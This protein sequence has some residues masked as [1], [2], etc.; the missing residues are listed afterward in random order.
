MRF[1]VPRSQLSCLNS[2]RTYLSTKKY[3][4]YVRN[5]ISC[6]FFGVYDVLQV[7]IFFVY[8]LLL[9]SIV[10]TDGSPS[11]SPRVEVASGLVRRQITSHRAQAVLLGSSRGGFKAGNEGKLLLRGTIVN[12]TYSIHKHLY[13]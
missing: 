6:F 3:I 10:D 4:L 8:S 1:P 12:R 11:A 5:L 2:V 9:Y 7:V 13:I